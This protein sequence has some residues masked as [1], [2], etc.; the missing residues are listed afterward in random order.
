MNEAQQLS[1]EAAD[2]HKSCDFVRAGF[3]DADNRRSSTPTSGRFIPD[4]QYLDVASESVLCRLLYST[5]S[6][7]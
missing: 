7:H 6:G 5:K 3:C 1:N 4:E 2:L